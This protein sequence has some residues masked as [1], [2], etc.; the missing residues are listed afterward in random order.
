MNSLYVAIGLGSGINRSKSG[1]KN[2]KIVV[3]SWIG[4]Q[5]SGGSGSRSTEVAGEGEG[6]GTG[7][8]SAGDKTEP[9]ADLEETREEAAKTAA[10]GSRVESLG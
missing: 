6:G 10:T 7:R 9:G 4:Q 3:M 1:R 8:A 5:R 2:K